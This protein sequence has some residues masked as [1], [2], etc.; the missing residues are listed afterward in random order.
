MKTQICLVSQQA[1]ANL[2]P[3]LDES[4]KP[5]KIV[6]VVTG[7]MRRQADNLHDVLKQCAIKVDTFY[8]T[9][10]QDYYQTAQDL[11]NLAASIEDDDVTLNITGGTKLI[12]VAAQSVADASGWKM[13]YVDADSDKII[14]LGREQKP[15]QSLQQ[16]LRLRHYLMSYGFK[17]SAEQQ[18]KQAT[19]QQVELTQTLVQQAGSLQDS[20]SLLNALTQEAENKGKLSI[21]LTDKHLDSPSLDVLLRNFEKAGALHLEKNIIRFS[22]VDARNFVKGG[23][24]EL[25]AINAVHQVHKDIGIQDKAIG[26]EIEEISSGTRNEL[27]IAFMAMNRLFVIECKTARIDKIQFKDDKLIPPKAND[28]LFKLAENCRRIG[29]LGARGLLL[30]YRKLGSAEIRLANSLGIHVVHG[31]EIARLPEKL[32]AWV[33]PQ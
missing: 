32:K 30:S 25:H 33:K 8:L 23:W 28:T 3:A 19:I 27:D 20:I 7:K 31:T 11:I 6:L 12:S 2:L 24:L 22:D 10:E 13:F 17:L 5:D 1:A 26:L 16:K 9:N 4:L 18:R 15:P 29:G 14:W 21:T